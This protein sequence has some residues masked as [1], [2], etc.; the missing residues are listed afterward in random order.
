M[1]RAIEHFAGYLTLER[2]LSVNSVSAYSS[3]LRD[4]AVWLDKHGRRDYGAVNRDDILSYLGDLKDSGMEPATLARR[5]V[6]IKMLSVIFF[7]SG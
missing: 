2:G 7:R 4:F 3:D 6:S 5:L 1:E